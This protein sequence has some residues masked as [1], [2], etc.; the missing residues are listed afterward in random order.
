VPQRQ[1]EDILIE[2]ARAGHRV[3][4]LKG[5]DPFVFGRGGEELQALQAAGIETQV[6]PGISAALGC[7]ASAGI[8]LTHRDC[9]QAATLITGQAKPGAPEPDW[10][11]LSA[12]ENTLAVYM[13]VGAA[14][15]IAGRL[16]AAGRDPETPVAVVENGTLPNERVLKG[17]LHELELLVE[18]FEV[19]GPAILYIGEVAA[20]ARGETLA[21]ARTQEVAA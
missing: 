15:K 12:P 5:G 6:V 18:G 8:P 1:I 17:A 11:G 7:A 4:R 2:E 10:G 16:L 3:V 20:F 9:A 13:G 19:K 21:Q 14:G